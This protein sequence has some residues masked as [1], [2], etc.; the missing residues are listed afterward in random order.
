MSLLRNLG[1]GLRSLFRKE[2]VNRELDE[3]LGQ[4]VRGQS[5]GE[6]TPVAPCPTRSR[7]P[8]FLAFE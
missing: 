3:E 4:V 1:S 7:I 2:Q 8:S 5:R 6:R